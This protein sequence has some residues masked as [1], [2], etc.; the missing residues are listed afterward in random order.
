MLNVIGF[1]KLK[2]KHKII[3]KKKYH[4]VLK[5]KFRKIYK[6]MSQLALKIKA[7]QYVSQ[8]NNIN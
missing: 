2:L 8:N 4:N 6:T 7:I 5:K 1:T 3:L